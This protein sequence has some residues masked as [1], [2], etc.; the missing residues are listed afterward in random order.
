LR[1]AAYVRSGQTAIAID[2]GPD[3][4][5]QMLVNH[6]TELDAILVT[7]Q[8]NDHIIGLDDV[9]PFNFLTWSDMPVYASPPVLAEF[10]KRFA[11]IFEENPYPGAPRVK[12]LPLHKD[13]PLALGGLHI[14]PVEA[15]HGRLPVLGFRIG[16]V[17][18]M[19]DVLT[20]PP[21]EMEKLRGLRCLVLSALR[22]K[23]HHAHLSLDQALELIERLQPETTYLTHL[24]HHMGFHADVEA[25]LPPTVHLGYD[26][27]RLRWD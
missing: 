13:E 26:G 18:Y 7:H 16:D 27:L 24:S 22:R 9:R 17:A 25:E 23:P 2:C 11:Y 19:T 6:I 3:F 8:H 15:L 21:E 10:R 5:Q 4:R 1:T 14:Q 20:I 12:L